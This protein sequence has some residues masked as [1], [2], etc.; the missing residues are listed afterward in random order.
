[1]RPAEV[2]RLRLDQQGVAAARFAKSSD[3]VGWFGVRST[4][5][6]AVTVSSS[7]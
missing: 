5:P 1:M 4:R 3:V 7:V 6:R 2:A